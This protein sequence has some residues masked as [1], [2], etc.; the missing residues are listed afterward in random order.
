MKTVRYSVAILAVL[1]VVSTPAMAGLF[2]FS[3]SN[4]HTAFDGVDSFTTTH[5]PST[6]GSVYRNSPPA[7]TAVFLS[8]FWGMGSEGFLIDMKISDITATTATGH[9][10]F[11]VEDMDGDAIA[12]T[13][14]GAWQKVNGNG[15]FVGSMTDVTYAGADDSF[16]GHF[17]AMSTVFDT[18]A[19]W[20]GTLLQL[21]ATGGWFADLQG[22]AKE[23]TVQG[24]SID[25]YVPVPAAALL[26]AIGIGAAGVRLRRFV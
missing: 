11:S 20:S 7:G 12:G 8:P 16:D 22:V 21:T 14:S 4:L 5:T 24:G 10:T 23:F 1:S 13:L 15:V 26:G 2:G 3:Y 18:P 25:A 17:G 19:P 9:G 6:V